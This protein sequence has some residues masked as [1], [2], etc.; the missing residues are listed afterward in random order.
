MTPHPTLE[1]L[2]VYA[3]GIADDAERAAIGGHVAECPECLP[4]LGSAEDLAWGLAAAAARP[5]PARLREI[6]VA[7]HRPRA[8]AWPLLR[9]GLAAAAAL[10]VV[11]G[12]ALAQSRAEI[13]RVRAERDEYARTLA[14]LAWEGRVVTLAPTQAGPPDARAAV[15][16]A[17]GGQAYLVLDLPAPPE[18]K[19]YEAWVIR[20]RPIPAGIAPTR[21]GVVVLRMTTVPGAGDTAA[22]TLE[23]AAGVSAPTSDPILVGKL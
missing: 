17:P 18:G 22:V 13:E 10:V 8:F 5:A 1:E 19:A 20:D 2:A 23:V 9:I 4:R 16:F 3:T 15:V 14:A 7:S 6:V 21:D 11:L 12:V